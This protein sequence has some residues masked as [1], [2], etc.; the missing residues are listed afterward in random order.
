MELHGY[1]TTIYASLAT[2]F[3]GTKTA[4]FTIKKAKNTMSMKINAAGT[5]NCKFLTKPVI[6]KIKEKVVK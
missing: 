1:E 6:F 4:A 2:Y 5:K 3:T